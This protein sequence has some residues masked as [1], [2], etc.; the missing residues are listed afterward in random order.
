MKG[1]A[2]QILGPPVCTNLRSTGSKKH[3]PVHR[4]G[5][6]PTTLQFEAAALPTELHVYFP[7]LIEKEG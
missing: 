5:F 2:L 4:A 6:E 1:S 7:F 3:S